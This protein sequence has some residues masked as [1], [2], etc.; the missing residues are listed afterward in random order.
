MPWVW[1]GE[2]QGEKGRLKVWIS[3]WLSSRNKELASMWRGKQTSPCKSRDWARTR[4]EEFLEG[5]VQLK[6]KKN[7]Q[8]VISSNGAGFCRPCVGPWHMRAANVET[9]SSAKH[10]RNHKWDERE[11]WT[12][13]PP[14]PNPAQMTSAGLTPQARMRA[15][16]PPR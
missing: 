15:G 7:L 8:S 11:R 6:I 10:R 5:K 16:L 2:K 14:S 9:G 13:T 3:P 1:N 12:W 4:G